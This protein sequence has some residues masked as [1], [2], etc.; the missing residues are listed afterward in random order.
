MR[1]FD[2]LDLTPLRKFFP[3]AWEYLDNTQNWLGWHLSHSWQN[4]RWLSSRL[5]SNW[6]ISTCSLAAGCG[7]FSLLE[8]LS[9]LFIFP[10]VCS[11]TFPQLVLMQNH[12]LIVLLMCFQSYQNMFLIIIWW[13]LWHVFVSCS[14]SGTAGFLVWSLVLHLML[15]T[16]PIWQLAFSQVLWACNPH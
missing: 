3:G 15:E 4:K 8:S 6:C 1:H 5:M 12:L 13:S 2:D 7:R 16:L 11:K 10:V 9:L 14:N